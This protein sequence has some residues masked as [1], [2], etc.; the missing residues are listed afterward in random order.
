MKMTAKNLKMMMRILRTEKFT[1]CFL[2][3]HAAQFF[4]RLAFL[5]LEM[6]LNFVVLRGGIRAALRFLD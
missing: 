2:C 6:R 5:A 4:A 1:L 3:I